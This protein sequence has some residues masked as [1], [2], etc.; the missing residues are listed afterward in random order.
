MMKY[1]IL[2]LAF[3]G[4]SLLFYL[5]YAWLFQRRQTLSRRMDEIRSTAT[6][7]SENRFKN[8]F[9]DRIL[10]PIYERLVGLLLRLTPESINLQYQTLIYHAGE[11]KR[12][13]PVTVI[14]FQLLIGFAVGFL[15]FIMMIF[16]ENRNFALVL[17]GSGVGF[18]LPYSLIKTNGNKRRREIEQK[19]P[20]FLDILY[21]SVEAGLGFYMALKRVTERRTDVLGME[22]KWALDDISKGKD[23]FEALREV[24]ART[25]VEDLN[26]FLTA[27]I[28]AEQL[29][30]NIAKL[31]KTQSKMM[32]LK[33]RQRSEE[34]AMKLP[35][36]LIFPI[37][38]FLFPVIY[39]VVLGP[40]ILNAFE[41]LKGVFF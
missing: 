16:A 28:Q 34:A 36:K 4:F 30:T 33:R 29:G 27:I 22:L 38:F 35:I 21:I 8:S 9:Y 3:I 32:R 14:A 39:I 17:V 6:D 31:L 1:L 18:Y 7:K 12:L 11:S 20:D 40:A 15:L 24:Y 25:G 19:L 2:L 10:R 41:N 37:I 23:R 26:S 5:L 13:K